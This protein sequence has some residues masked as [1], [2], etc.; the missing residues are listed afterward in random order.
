MTRKQIGAVLGSVV[1]AVAAPLLVLALLHSLGGTAQADLPDP[2][3]KTS[4]PDFGQHSKN[5][6]WVAA[7]SNSFWWFANTGTYPEL[8]DPGDEYIEPLSRNAAGVDNYDPHDLDGDNFTNEPDGVPDWFDYNDRPENTGFVYDGT[9]GDYADNDA[10][11][12][13]LVDFLAMLPPP[14]PP[15]PPDPDCTSFAAPLGDDDSDGSVDEDPIN[16]GVDEDGDGNVDEDPV[17][18]V[19]D[20]VPPDGLID[21]DPPAYDDDGNNGADEDGVVGYRTLLKKVA[22]AVWQ[23]T[24]EDGIKDPNERNYVY[25]EPVEKWDYLIGL[26]A[27]IDAHGADLQV[28]DVLH[29]NYTGKGMIPPTNESH[30][31]VASARPSQLTAQAAANSGVSQ[32]VRRP[33]LDDYKTELSRSQDVLVWMCRQNPQFDWYCHVVTAQGYDTTDPD[34]ANHFITVSDPWTHDAAAHDDTWLNKGTGPDHNNDY[35]HDPEPYDD[36]DVVTAGSNNPPVEDFVIDCGGTQWTVIDLIFIS[37]PGPDVKILDWGTTAPSPIEIGLGIP[38]T[39]LV[40]EVKHNNGPGDVTASATWTAEIT[41]GDP[42]GLRIKWINQPTDGCTLDGA[43]VSCSNPDVNDLEFEV[44]LEESVDVDLARDL[45]LEGLTA[46]TYGVTLV[47]AEWPMDP[48]GG[49]GYDHDPSNNVATTTIFVNVD[50]PAGSV[51]KAVTDITFDDALLYPD[52]GADIGNDLWILK[53][54]NVPFSVTSQDINNGPDDAEDAEISFYAFVPAGCSGRWYDPQSYFPFDIQTIGGDY[55]QMSSGTEWFPPAK[56][57]GPVWLDLHFQT[58]EYTNAGYSGYEEPG[59]SINRYTRFFEIHCYEADPTPYVFTFCNRADVKNDTDPDPDNNLLCEDLNVWSL[60]NADIK[61][62]TFYSDP[63]PLPAFDV[64]TYNVISMIEDKHNN[65]PQDAWSS[66]SWTMDPIE[67]RDGDGIPDINVRWEAKIGDLCTYQ[68]NPV[69]CGEG[70]GVGT[71]GSGDGFPSLTGDNCQDDFDN[72]GDGTCDINGCTAYPGMGDADCQVDIDDIHFWVDLPVS[73]DTQV[74]RPLKLHCKIGGNYTLTLYNDEWPG[75]PDNPDEIWEDPEPENNSVQMDLD[76]ICKG[77]P[78]YKGYSIYDPDAP[79]V[80]EYVTIQDQFH[81]DYLQVLGPELLMTPAI[82]YVDGEYAGGDMA[83]TH[84]KCYAIPGTY[85]PDVV[86]NLTTQF[87]TEADIDVGPAVRLCI[88]TLKEVTYPEPVPPPSGPVPLEPHYVCYDTPAATPPPGLIIDLETQFGSEVDVQFSSTR[89]SQLCAPALKNGDGDLTAPHLRCYPIDSTDDPPHRVNLQTQF[90]LETEV[91][92]NEPLWM[93]VPA[94][95]EIVGPEADKEVMAIIFDEADNYPLEGTELSPSNEFTIQA[96]E[97]EAFSVTSVEYNWG[98]DE[99]ADAEISFYAHVPA[100]CSGRWLDQQ[101]TG[102]PDF[103]FDIQTIDG[104]YNVPSSGTTYF[105]PTKEP[106]PRWLDLHFQ[107][108]EYGLTEP[109]AIED[110]GPNEGLCN[111]GIDND[112]DGFCDFIPDFCG[113]GSIPDPD[114]DVA[115][116]AERYT[117]FFEIHCYEDADYV[118]EF[119]NRADVKS[120]DTDPDL[121]NNLRCATLTV[122][123]QAPT[124]EACCYPDGSCQDLAPATC[125]TQGGT[126]LGQGSV[127]LGIEGCCSGGACTDADAACCTYLGDTP[128][129]SGSA[130]TGSQACCING[131]ATCTDCDGLCCDDLGGAL[132]GPVC[133]GDNNGNGIDDACEAAPAGVHYAAFSIFG[134]PPFVPPVDL[135]T[136]FGEELGVEVGPPVTLMAPALKNGEGT[137]DATHLKCYEIASS[138]DPFHLVDLTTQFGL[139]EDV[140]VGPARELCVPAAKEVIEPFPAPPGPL[141]T[142]PHYKCYEITGAAL[143]IPVEVVTQFGIEPVVILDVPTRLC[144]PALKNGEP[145]NLD[146]YPHLKCY[147]IPPGPPTGY[148]VNLE[149]QFGLEPMVEVGPALRLCMPAVKDLVCQPTAMPPVDTDGDTFT[150]DIETYLPTDCLDDCTDNPGV[151]DAWPLDINVD[152]VITVSGDVLNYRGRLQA[153]GGPPPDPN[154]LQRLDLNMD[155]VITVSGDVLLFRGML[156]QTCT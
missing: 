127:C 129:G 85:N 45:E 22:E 73:A 68:A 15:P 38:E 67:D 152:K 41:S 62:N 23:D 117:R 49:P 125:T 140:E 88:P 26:Q 138:E 16:A 118:F 56:E 139:E 10:I 75:N 28:H 63:D 48:G 111:D 27:Y 20:D 47:N 142:E 60:H 36:C 7:A 50:S 78:H 104:D 131:G 143:G 25:S 149:T 113:P 79:A 61:V 147:D 116:N 77:E 33:T 9:C 145:G 124:V 57:A 102:M 99:P 108:A 84:L 95:K 93:C 53:S 35:K 31:A 4:M 132:G 76:V 19:D 135:E 51:D 96:S 133:L 82:K 46:G 137:L 112:L 32:I 123:S 37:P 90:P 130:C 2:Y 120:P 42:A 115:A 119:C 91:E 126:P 105:P 21:E 80:G 3:E 5:W 54:E 114:C 81:T 101:A 44:D 136:Q 155:N 43:P 69:P 58:A 106:G 17:N 13:G 98:P 87:G 92:I 11:P 154:W 18:G 59:G 151:H 110:P 122:H 6:C 97:N 24:D 83:Q 70:D 12:D 74:V 89:A 128:Q 150:D 109:V 34:P 65:G 134:D 64:S 146:D 103:P 29:P 107:T 94:V 144:A 141:E 55:S 100:G 86:V 1:L 153:S 71:G 39:I 30:G 148:I 14:I 40:E 8:M 72:D 156:Q 66:V 121:T 52:E